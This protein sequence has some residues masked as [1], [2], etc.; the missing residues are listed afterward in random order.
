VRDLSSKKAR[1]FEKESGRKFENDSSSLNEQLSRVNPS[2]FPVARGFPGV[3][4]EGELRA[5]PS[6]LSEQ[7]EVLWAN[8]VDRG[9]T[10]KEVLIVVESGAGGGGNQILTIVKNQRRVSLSRNTQRCYGQTELTGEF[11]V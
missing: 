11:S 4:P 6:L 8:G 3:Q 10:F 5:P 1:N 9:I 2:N 7:P